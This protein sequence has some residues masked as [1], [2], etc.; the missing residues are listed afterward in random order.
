MAFDQ[1][2]AGDSVV[3]PLCDNHLDS[4][5]CQVARVCYEVHRQALHEVLFKIPIGAVLSAIVYG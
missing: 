3:D 1:F 4:C 5:Q 2:L